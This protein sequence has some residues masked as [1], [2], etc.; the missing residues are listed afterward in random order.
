[1]NLFCRGFLV[2]ISKF[3]HF[4]CKGF[5]SSIFFSRRVSFAFV[6]GLS[7]CCSILLR[8]S[9]V[10]I[11]IFLGRISLWPVLCPRDHAEVR[12]FGFAGSSLKWSTR[13]QEVL[14][15]F[16][17]VF[18]WSAGGPQEGGEG[19]MFQGKETGRPKDTGLGSKGSPKGNKEPGAGAF[20]V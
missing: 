6:W 3:V 14:L 9:C 17:L 16:A 5:P 19:W 13:R 12:Y 8:A 15:T 11:F 10:S 4:G 2:G 18:V 7:P 1:M 20:W